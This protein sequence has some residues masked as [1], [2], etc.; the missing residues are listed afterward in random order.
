MLVIKPLLQ[1]TTYRLPLHY[2]TSSARVAGIPSQIPA[3][4]DRPWILGG[5]N[6]YQLYRADVL[7]T[8][9]F[10]NRDGS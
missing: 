8:T 10:D 5:H 7:R 1:T 4:V 9:T 2:T 3:T 6:L